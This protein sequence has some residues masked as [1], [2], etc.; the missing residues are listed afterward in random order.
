MATVAPAGDD[1]AP[2]YDSSLDVITTPPFHFSHL[3]PVKLKMDN[4]LIW[5][6]QILPIVRSRYLEGIVDGTLLCPSPAHHIYRPWVTQDQ[7]ILSAIQSSLTEGVAGMV[8]FA[9]TSHD[10]WEVLESS[11]S[12]QS[13]S[14]QS[15]ALRTQLNDI[16]K[17]HHSITV[18]FNKIKRL[19]DTLASIGEP[20]RDTEF[21]S[22][23]LEG[24][25]ADY[26]SLVEV[27]KERTIP[28]KPHELY[29]R[30]LSTEQ[31]LA[32]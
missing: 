16:H 22:Y 8:L 7:A 14:S 1:A 5:R 29:Q 3:L 20:L 27:I 4:Y 32:G 13:S 19:A 17:E 15:M 18:Y 11:F 31:R 26:D 30:L 25:D 21:T 24:L 9:T 28:I 6:A 12:A 2:P 10:A 23:I